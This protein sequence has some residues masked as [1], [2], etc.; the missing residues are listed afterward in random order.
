MTKKTH[1]GMELCGGRRAEKKRSKDDVEKHQ[2]ITF[3]LMILRDER[4]VI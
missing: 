1:R 3:H 2:G 4:Q